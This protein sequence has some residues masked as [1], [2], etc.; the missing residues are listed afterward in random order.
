MN[1]NE[2]KAGFLSWLADGQ[3]QHVQDYSSRGRS[4]EAM[5]ID[6]LHGEWVALIRDWVENPHDYA[7]P[8]RGGIEAEYTLRCLE[9][10]YAMVKD[11]FQAI[12]SFAETAVANLDD[13]DKSRINEELADEL[14]DFLTQEHSR[15]S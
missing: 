9:P 15:R 13:I 8:R 4:F 12:R 2:L 10:P 7:N 1:E 6:R 14:A 5:P 3:M 11:E